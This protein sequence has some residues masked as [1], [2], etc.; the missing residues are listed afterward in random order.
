M[1]QA[2]HNQQH[3]LW[4][5]CG[6]EPQPFVDNSFRNRTATNAGF[7]FLQTVDMGGNATYFGETNHLHL[8][9]REKSPRM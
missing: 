6:S 3:G 2:S 5:I 1:M 7:E 4:A 9:G 8:Q